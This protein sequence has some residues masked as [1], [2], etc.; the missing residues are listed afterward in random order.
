MIVHGKAMFNI[1]QLFAALF[2]AAI[3][4]LALFWAVVLLEKKLIPWRKR[5]EA[6]LG[7]Y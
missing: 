3:V 7:A 2:L 1:P 4:G 6:T 5:A